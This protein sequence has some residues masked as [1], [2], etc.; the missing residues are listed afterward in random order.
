MP[1]KWILWLPS[2]KKHL[3]IKIFGEFFFCNLWLD[4]QNLLCKTKANATSE[5]THKNWTQFSKICSEKYSVFGLLNRKNKFS[6]TTKCN[7]LH[8]VPKGWNEN[9]NHE[10]PPDLLVEKYSFP[11]PRS[12]IHSTSSDFRNTYSV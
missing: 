8:R 4:S 12:S 5:K 11:W 3:R 6:K 2:G 1:A 9:L 7:R 10:F